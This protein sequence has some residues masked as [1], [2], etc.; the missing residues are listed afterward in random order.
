MEPDDIDAV[1]DGFGDGGRRW[2]S[3]PG[4]DGVE[5]NAGQ[6]SLVRQFL[7]GLTNQRG[8]DYGTDRLRFAREVLRARA[9]RRRRRRRRAAP[10]VRR[11]GAVGRHHAR[12]RRP[13]SPPRWRR[14]VDYLVVVRGGDLLGRA[15][16]ARLP[17]AARLQPRPDRRRPRRRRRS[18]SPSFAQGS[19]VDVGQAEWALGDG[20]A[21]TA[22]R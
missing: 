19:I 20:V 1:V 9:G 14:A 17:R 15:D 12:G 21:A 2:P 13:R 5:V 7:S 16:P 11:A 4:C 3:T 18:A 6:H 22:S 8:D 10:V